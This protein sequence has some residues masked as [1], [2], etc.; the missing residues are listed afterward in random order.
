MSQ[1]WV[2]LPSTLMGSSAALIGGKCLGQAKGVLPCSDQTTPEGPAGQGRAM[3][4]EAPSKAGPGFLR[5]V[6]WGGAL[7]YR[8]GPRPA[9]EAGF[10]Q[11][12]R[13][14]LHVTV[15]R[16]FFFFLSFCL[17]LELLPRHMEVPRLGVESEL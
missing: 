12:A 13:S 8:G 7:V 1:Q 16:F 6:A 11:Q 17:F 14:R 3:E 15:W 2:P 10:V 9:M 5:G 4:R